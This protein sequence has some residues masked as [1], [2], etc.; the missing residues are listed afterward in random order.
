MKI[1][2]TKTHE[3][4]EEVDISFPYYYEY[5]LAAVRSCDIYGKID[6]KE[7]TQIRFDE[8]WQH[9]AN[10]EFTIYET[11]WSDCSCYLKEEYKSTEAEFLAAKAKAMEIL[12]RA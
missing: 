11:K 4:V 1:Q 10:V 3:T 6:E 7:H 5:E 8:H 12:S 2:I 9:I